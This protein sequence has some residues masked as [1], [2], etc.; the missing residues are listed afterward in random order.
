MRISHQEST[1]CGR[2]YAL[3]AGT[4]ILLVS[5]TV[6]AQPTSGTV[7]SGPFHLDYRIEGNGRPAIVIGFPTY[8]RRIFGDGLGSHFRLIYVDHRGSAPSP[9]PVSVAE[10]GLDKISGDIELVRSELDLG[11]V[12]IIGHSG[13]ALLALEYAKMYPGSVSHVVMIGIAPDLS[14][15]SS[16]LA[17]SYWEESAS[18]ARKAALER[19][20]ADVPEDEPETYPGESFIRSYVRNGPMAWYD[21]EFDSTPLWEGVE[22]NMAMF[23][24]VWGKLL[25][26]LDVSAGLADLKRP[27][28]LALGK[29]DYLV[30]PPAS[31]DPVK[32]A[33]KDLT[34][35]IYEKSGHTP[36]FEEAAL[37]NADL[38]EWIDRTAPG[39]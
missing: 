25:A 28:F 30:A 20:W 16:A 14:D 13:H 10:F 39:N 6:V 19:N 3:A 36:Q 1:V 8:Y 21:Y 33:F 35:K 27:V 38:L 12:V 34:I 31:W 2:I 5:L 26:E 32:P 23:N 37:F 11:P 9:G 29:Y 24:H 22:V 4:A 18:A 7:A 15:E 17:D